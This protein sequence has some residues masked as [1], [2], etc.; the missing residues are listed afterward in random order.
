MA[1]HDLI[2]V[3]VFSGTKEPLKRLNLHKEWISQ[4]NGTFESVVDEKPTF[5]G[6]DPHN[7]LIDR[8]PADNLIEVEKPQR[9]SG[10]VRVAQ[11]LFVRHDKNAVPICRR[12]VK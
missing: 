12:L 5:A 7:K 9:L 6:I 3:G 11:P 10:G 2:D 4:E 8:D 1:I